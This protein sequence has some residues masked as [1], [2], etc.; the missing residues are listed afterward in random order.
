MIKMNHN[1]GQYCN[2]TID[3]PYPSIETKS[4]RPEYAHAMLSNIGSD[5]SEMTA[6]SLYF[7]NS[8]ILNPDYAHFAQCFHEI[9]IVEMHHLNI[10]AALAYQM[11][12]DPRLWSMQKYDTCYWTPAYNEYPREIRRV[13]ENS[14]KS[15]LAAIQKYTRQ[16]ETINDQNIV[17]IL[18]RI[19]LDEQQHVDIFAAML[20]QID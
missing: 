20:E 2:V 19:I 7:Y 11:G 3:L 15:E 16:A 5:N 12:L 9:S 8:V 17:E 14:L 18:E 4:R 6:V 10:F 1:G 13:I